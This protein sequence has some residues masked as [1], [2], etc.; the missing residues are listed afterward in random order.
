MI[1]RV[2]L[3]SGPCGTKSTQAH[4]LM[5]LAKKN[6]HKADFVRETVKDKAYAG[7]KFLVPSEQ[8]KI[9]SEQIYLEELYLSCGVD[10]IITESPTLLPLQYAQI[11]KMD[12]FLAAMEI[13]HKIHDSRFK[14]LNFW[15]K[16][17]LTKE[18]YETEGRFQTFEQAINVHSIIYNAAKIVYPDLIE[19]KFD[20][21]DTMFEI[22]KKNVKIM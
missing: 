22:I 14:S 18:T 2:C 13:A 8:L 9:L 16:R 11:N 5:Y 7:D 6:G 21:I 20:D 4:G 12:S 17:E 10:Y 1:R 3:Y 19:V 15:L